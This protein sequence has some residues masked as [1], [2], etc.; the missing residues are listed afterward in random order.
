[1]TEGPADTGANPHAE[2]GW[3]CVDPFMKDGRYDHGA[4]DT[5]RYKEGFLKR[6]WAKPSE[7]EVVTF[8]GPG[9]GQD[10]IPVKLLDKTSR[11]ITLTRDIWQF[12][13]APWYRQLSWMPNNRFRVE[14][15]LEELTEAGE[16]CLDTEEGVV[17]FK[18]PQ[19]ELTADDTVVAPCLKTLIIF[20]GTEWIFIKGLTFTETIGGDNIHRDGMA[21]YGAMFPRAE[22]TYCGEAIRMRRAS[23]CIIEKCRFDQTGGNGIYLESGCRR[24]HIAYNTFCR[25]GASGVVL[26]G[27]HLAHPLYNRIENNH[28]FECGV[29]NKFAA[30]ILLGVSDGNLIA[31]NHIH[32]MPHHAINL[33]T[34]GRGRNYVE[35][36]RIERVA[37]ETFDTGAINCWMDMYSAGI[38]KEA[39]RSGHVIRYNYIADTLGCR[40]NE[41]G[42]IEAPVEETLGI[43]LDDCSSN[44]LIYGNIILR[45]GFAV[46]VH[47]GKNNL[48][49]N[50]IVIDCKALLHLQDTVSRRPGNKDLADFMRGNRVERNIVISDREKSAVISIAKWNENAI[51]FSNRNLCFGGLLKTHFIVGPYFGKP[52]SIDEWRSYGFD[53]ESI[54]A[55]P[56]FRDPANNDYSLLPNSP[57]FKQGF[58]PINLM[59]IGIRKVDPR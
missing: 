43:Y 26:I 19:G 7:G 32:D 1:M 35:Y 58:Q 49:E 18:P 8:C 14:N 40:V 6:D 36:N 21:G 50:N 15:I 20:S 38:I 16:W 22:W 37:R 55:D 2:T 5:F 41:R 11:T 9:W 56:L 45:V 53:E 12:D 27:D 28:I 24:N 4:A 17:Y 57:A 54:F 33:G 29:L 13:V 25:C 44:C 48:I 47:L 30:G 34:N 39:E 52:L 10:I 59:Q 46:Q 23:N 3:G 42:E 31:H 51:S